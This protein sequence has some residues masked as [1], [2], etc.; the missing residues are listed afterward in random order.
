M[1]LIRSSILN[2]PFSHPTLLSFTHFVSL[3]IT[4]HLIVFTFI[5]TML[6]LPEIDNMICQQ[7]SRHDLTQCARV[8]KKWHTIVIPYIWHDLSSVLTWSNKSLFRRT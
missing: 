3:L 4:L 8:N 7:L 6:D 1:S 2:R 5:A